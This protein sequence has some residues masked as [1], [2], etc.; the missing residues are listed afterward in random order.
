MFITWKY[1]LINRFLK[2][3]NDNYRKVSFYW[4][5][6]YILKSWEEDNEILMKDCDTE[7]KVVKH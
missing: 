1:V 4:V 2:G 3:L 7:V 6:D 5:G